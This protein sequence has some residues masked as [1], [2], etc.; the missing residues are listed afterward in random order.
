MSQVRKRPGTLRAPVRREEA[1]VSV[2]PLLRDMMDGA[3]DLVRELEARYHG[4]PLMS[5]FRTPEGRA[6]VRTAVLSTQDGAA[7]LTVEMDVRDGAV[8]WAYRLSSMLGIR[9]VQRDLSELDRRYW[10]DL[11]REGEPEPAFLWSATRW[12]S[13]YLIGSSHRYYVNLFAFSPQHAEA[14]ARL[15][16]EAARKLLDWLD[17]GWFPPAPAET[18]LA[19]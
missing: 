17:A 15:T 13:D 3:V 16:P 8:E 4:P 9:F 2:P 10:L 19:W 6:S 18:P 14:A 7:T 12:Q 11:M 1:A 5:L